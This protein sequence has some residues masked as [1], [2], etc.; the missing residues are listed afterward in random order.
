MSIMSMYLN[1]QATL[2]RF[3]D[4]DDC[5]MPTYN[6]P[7]VIR[8]RKQPIGAFERSTFSDSKK[9]ETIY[10]T[11]TAVSTGDRLDGHIVLNTHEMVNLPGA[12]VGYKAV[13]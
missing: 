9:P 11:E 6:A 1:Q 7:E 5:G 2:E 8:C 4:N 3:K 13:V 12:V 10:Y